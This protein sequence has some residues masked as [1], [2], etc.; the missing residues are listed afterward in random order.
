VSLLEEELARFDVPVEGSQPEK[1]ASQTPIDVYSGECGD[2][3]A[4]PKPA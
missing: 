3:G 1:I 2:E 4:H